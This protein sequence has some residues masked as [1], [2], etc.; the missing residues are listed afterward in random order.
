M[1]NPTDQTNYV[2]EFITNIHTVISNYKD[3]LGIAD[4]GKSDDHFIPKFPYITIEFDNM[5]EDWK[6][7]P[8][9][10]T[11]SATFSITCWYANLNDRNARQGL[12]TLL[13]KLGNVLREAWNVNSY[14]PQL[15]SEIKSIT[16]YVLAKENEIV[17]GGIISFQCNKVITVTIIP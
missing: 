3:F 8:R 2:E 7:M 4:V 13:S 6:E 5:V 14:C 17:L 1:A 11:L 10:K 15:G 16:P 12:R 9:R